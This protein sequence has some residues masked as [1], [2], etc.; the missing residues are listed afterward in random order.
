MRL[1]ETYHTTLGEN[2]VQGCTFDQC[3]DDYRLSMLFTLARTGVL[4]GRQLSAL[5]Q[6]R[7]VD[8]LLPRADAAVIDLNA[9]E[10]L[11]G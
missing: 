9:V 1:L 3:V 11:P 7:F 5:H 6:R 2:G 10:L 4:I 8:V